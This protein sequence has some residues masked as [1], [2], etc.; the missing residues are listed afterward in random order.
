VRGPA[1]ARG[2]L[3]AAALA[4]SVQLGAC[5]YEAADPDS[6]AGIVFTSIDPPDGAVDV[7]TDVVFQLGTSA[8]LDDRTVSGGA[9]RLHSG[10]LASWLM[11]Y[12]D[13]AGR[14]V[15]VW[16]SAKLRDGADWVLALE[17]EIAGRD[18]GRIAAGPVTGFT[19]GDGPGGLAPFP[20]LR[21]EPDLRPIFEARCASCHG[22]DAPVAGLALDGPSAVTDTALGVSSQG[23]PSLDRIKPGRPGQS[24]MV[25]KIIDDGGTAGARMPRSF[26]ADEP[27]APLTTAEQQA[28][29]DWIAGGAVMEP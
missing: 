29:S 2:L 17:D 14:R 8:H 18:G 9:F 28:I 10:S 7:P 26:Y 22:G 27:A 13:P 16:P 23:D 1:K 6:D 5:A 4:A 15:V 20:E 21:Y 24:Y 11:A 19:T 3:C 25:Y 12:Y